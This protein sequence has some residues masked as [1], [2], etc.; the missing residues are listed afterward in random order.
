LKKNR[1]LLWAPKFAVADGVV[2]AVDED[3]GE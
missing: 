3:V 1:H 2:A